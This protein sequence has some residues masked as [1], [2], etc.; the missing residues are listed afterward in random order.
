[1]LD[2]RV[3]F[4]TARGFSPDSGPRGGEETG[5]A[6]GARSVA[7]GPAVCPELALI[8][9][10]QN[11]EQ[12]AFREIVERNQAK[13]LS[14]IHCILRNC[15]DAQDVAQQVFTKIYLSLGQFNFRSALLTWITRIA[16]NECYDY[17]RKR[18][19]RRLTYESDLS[20]ADLHQMKNREDARRNPAETVD[21]SIELRECVVRLLDEL[22]EEERSLLIWKE[23]EGYPVKE[24]ARM[25][26][27]NVNT[28][29]VKLFRAKVKAAQRASVARTRLK[30]ARLSPP[31]ALH[32]QFCPEM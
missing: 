29:K 26:A 16:V 1:M 19:I 3:P 20:P 2:N 27:M 13:V 8:R 14:I 23:V 5:P 15:N 17:L 12:E 9:R 31:A 7:A 4:D 10:A 21:R 18:K 28:V 11:G 25:V 22:S 32:E 30:P 24:L 6:L